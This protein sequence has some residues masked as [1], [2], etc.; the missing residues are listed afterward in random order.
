MP[1]AMPVKIKELPGGYCLVDARG[2]QFAYCYGED[3]SDR[4]MAAN[5]ESRDE[6]LERVRQIARALTAADQNR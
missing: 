6:A 1:I 4:A 5:L 3:R 2:H